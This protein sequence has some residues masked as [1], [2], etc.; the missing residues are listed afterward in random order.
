VSNIEF[1]RLEVFAT[2]EEI[3]HIKDCQNKPYM[4]MTNPA[5]PGLGVSHVVPMFEQ[6]LEAA[7]RAAL[8]HG[9]ADFDGFYGIDLSNGQFVR[10]K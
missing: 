4:F 10:P 3:A 1:D 9:L 8:A 5:P 7:H 6:P 2:A